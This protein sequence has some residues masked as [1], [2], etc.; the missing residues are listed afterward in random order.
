[1]KRGCCKCISVDIDNI[2]AETYLI[3]SNQELCE[4]NMYIQRNRGDILFA[5]QWF[6]YEG[7]TEDVIIPY[8]ASL[9]GTEFDENGING[10]MYRNNGSARAFIKLAKVLDIPWVVL[11]D[12]DEQGKATMQEVV[13]C[14]YSKE[15]VAERV[16]LT[17]EKDI[18]HE[19]ARSKTIL[20]DYELLLGEDISEEDKQLKIDGKDDEYREAIVSKIQKGKVENAYKLLELWDKRSFD[21]N[22]IPT[23]IKTLIRKV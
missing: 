5:R 18:E 8:F 20:N 19:L 14:G 15:Y 22:E 7:Q 13:N 17:N 23:V 10:I 2:I 4:V 12:N 9:L 3:F 11:G 1:M 6:L 16:A 21:K